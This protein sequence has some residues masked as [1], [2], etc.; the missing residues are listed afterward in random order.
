MSKKYPW[1]RSRTLYRAYLVEDYLHYHIGALW[2][3]THSFIEVLSQCDGV[4]VEIVKTTRWVKTKF[5]DEKISLAGMAPRKEL[6]Q[7]VITN[8]ET[9]EQKETP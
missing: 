6:I 3:E 4:P 5:V 7:E 2:C 8:A 9:I 1:T